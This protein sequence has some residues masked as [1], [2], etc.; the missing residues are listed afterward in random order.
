M[1]IMALA[2]TAVE[3]AIAEDTAAQPSLYSTAYL[4]H[5]PYEGA[6]ASTSTNIIRTPGNLGQVAA[7]HK[8]VETPFSSVHKSDV[9]YTN[10]I[11]PYPYAAAGPHPYA[12]GSYP[13]YAAGPHPYSA[14]PHPY[15]TVPHLYATG[16][17]PYVAVPR[18]YSYDATPIKAHG[19]VPAA[20]SPY[21]YGPVASPIVTP[22]SV[23]HTSFSGPYGAHYSYK[24]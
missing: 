4:P 15:S 2:V 24:R 5:N 23:S 9:R 20:A 3:D 6:V 8:T 21:G 17:Q 19:Y 1:T 22:H 10:D 14:G 13:A 16:P 18:P 7:F 11:Q 12:P